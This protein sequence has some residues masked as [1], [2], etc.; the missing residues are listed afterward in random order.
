MIS[1]RFLAFVVAGGTAACVNFGSRILFSKLMPYVPAIVLAYIAGMITA[2]A[3][4]RLFVFTEANNEIK[5][6]AFWFLLV[7][8]AAVAQTV[9]ISLAFARWVFPALTM[10]FHP[11]AIAHAIGVIVPVFTSYIGHKHFTFRTQ[12]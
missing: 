9:A 3:L 2:F 7:N 11:E 12:P 8:L 10:N 6:Q 4:N 1:R 5:N